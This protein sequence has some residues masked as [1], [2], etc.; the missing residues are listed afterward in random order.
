[1]VVNPPHRYNK[2][3]TGRPVR[4]LHFQREG[5][6]EKDILTLSLCQNHKEWNADLGVVLNEDT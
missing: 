1:M 6:I 4:L 5:S 3:Q 2:C